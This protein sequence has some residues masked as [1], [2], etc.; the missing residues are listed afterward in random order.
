MGGAKLDRLLVSAG[1]Y[2]FA[3]D[4][5]ATSVFSS[6]ENLITPRATAEWRYWR[7]RLKIDKPESLGDHG[8]N[9]YG[10][11]REDTVGAVALIESNGHATLAAGV[12]RCMI[13]LAVCPWSKF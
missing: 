2:D 1:A 4:K 3:R 11:P 8:D 13:S 10:P 5:L 9:A 7:Q 6:S 12:S